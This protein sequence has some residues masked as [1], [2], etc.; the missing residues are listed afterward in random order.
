M[1]ITWIKLY[2]YYSIILYSINMQK[3]VSIKSFLKFCSVKD[4]DKRM[5]RQ[6]TDWEKI[7]TKDTSEKGP[8]S[9]ICREL[10]ELNKKRSGL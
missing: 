4:A 2:T 1:L 6:A 9:K 5:R 3:Y 8:L 10:L 7:S